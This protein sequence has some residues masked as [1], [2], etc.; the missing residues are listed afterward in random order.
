M[1][2]FFNV[3][4]PFG[5]NTFSQTQWPYALNGLKRNSEIVTDYYKIRPFAVKSEHILARLLNSLGVSYMMNLERFYDLVD[6]RALPLSSSFRMTS[7]LNKGTMFKGIFF[8]EDSEEIL[9]ACDD[10]INPFYVYK[11]WK[12]VSAVKVIMHPKSDLGFTLPNGKKSGTDYGVSV[13]AINIPALAVQFKAFLD[14]QQI[15]F[16]DK[17]MN[18]QTVAQFIHM[19]VLPNMLGSQ[20]DIALF[21]RA[22]NLTVGAPMGDATKKHAFMLLDYS[23]YVDA[24][25]SQLVDF[26]KQ[27]DRHYKIILKSFFGIQQSNFED[28]FVLPD[29]AP[30]RQVVWAELVARIR[31]IE[32]L[33][34]LSPS[35][36]NH[37]NRSENN[38]FLRTIKLYENDSALRAVMSKNTEYEILYSIAEIKSLIG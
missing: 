29:N 27:N 8:G 16:I 2:T 30:T 19:Y 33:V 38:Y 17:G 6:S 31:V 25:Y 13:I 24:S 9:L 23:K 36:G 22:Y 5:Q 11:N 3:L 21:N 34:K 7:S 28:L 14:Y 18:P 26:F 10:S 1:R 37:L 20:L 15:N 4:S 12:D 35:N 32:F